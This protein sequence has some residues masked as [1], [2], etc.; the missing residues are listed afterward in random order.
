MDAVLQDLRYGFRILLKS[1][2]FT[3]VAVLTLALGIGANSAMFSVVNAVLLRPLP[4]PHSDRLI[5]IGEKDQRTPS[6]SVAFLSVSYPNFFDWRSQSRSFEQMASYH[7]TDATLT[8]ATVAHVHGQ[9]VSG[10]FF[11]VL[12]PS[13]SLGRG[14][15]REDEKVR[16]VVLSHALWQSAFAGDAA[17]V[18]KSVVLNGR[19]YSVTGVTAPT[20]EFPID[21]PRS[22]FWKTIADDAMA[23]PGEQAITEQRSAHFLQV[24][25]RLRPGLGL[26]QA[27]SEM[28]VISLALAKQYPATNARRGAA[29]L[30]PE[31][32]HL[33]GDVRPAL[34]LLLS[35]VGSVLLIACANIANLML[36][37]AIRRE[38]E[39][40]IRAALGADRSRLIRQLLTE[41][42]L[43]SITGGAAGL[44]LAS[45]GL[46]ALLRV[47]PLD[48][49]R[50]PNIGFDWRVL[51]F[52]FSL[53]IA[54]GVLFGLAPALH[55]VGAKL[56][57]SLNER[58]DM[59]SSRQGRTRSIL[60]V[61]ET[62]IGLV[63][64]VG[65]GLLIR[66]LWGL[67]HTNP[68][69][70]S[71]NVLTFKVDVPETRYPYSASVRFHRDLLDRIQ[72]LPGVASASAVLPLPLSDSHY[73][74]SFQITGHPLPESERPS[75]GFRA[76]SPGYLATMHVS[77]IKGRDFNVRDDDKSLGV[78]IVNQA[79]ADRFFPGEDPVGRHMRPDFSINGDPQDR[80]I[81]GVVGNIKDRSLSAEF[82][83]EY[84]VPLA[85]GMISSATICVRFA[86]DP[87]GLGPAIRSSLL[88][89]DK[90]IPAFDVRTMDDYV[91]LTTGRSRFDTL[92][93]TLFAGAALVMTTV[94][95]Y[96]V[97]AYIVVQRT[98]EIGIRVAL[99]ASREAILA[100]VLR[101]GLLITGIGILAGVAGSLAMTGLL[102][103]FVYQVKPMDPATYVAVTLLVAIVGL[104]A[105][106]IPAS[107]AA[108]VDP[109]VALRYE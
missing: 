93:L 64:L 27:R 40:S 61:G 77:L 107:R 23:D 88:G 6:G 31:P 41:S 83:P 55:S 70:D 1:P 17:I 2:G 30:I 66:S 57:N 29:V 105:T 95:L 58:T 87:T 22:D 35:A 65:A 56:G 72:A 100:M 43:L 45:I 19:S 7:D 46:K 48:I 86:S 75:A 15:P 73:Q 49:P 104:S 85:Q 92:L 103:R 38:R 89:L 4:F 9:V 109:M 53:A 3:A 91:S 33:V 32:Q 96:G 47:S 98:R 26:E 39:I 5:A 108:A 8:G 68:G 69:F 79:F 63:L 52:S 80:E 60:I 11:S 62:A 12:G 84:Y 14:F 74:V 37:R 42:L 20:F 10:D 101:Q 67:L 54:T 99:G 24:I 90:E 50:P 16:A 78:V 25:G 51:V 21:S 76:I 102:E 106:Y 28:D 59:S 82:N 81:V 94:G 13:F 34:V 18:G 97:M 71:H 44:L 36:A